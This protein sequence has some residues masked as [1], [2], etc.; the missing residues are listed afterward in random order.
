MRSGTG[1]VRANYEDEKTKKELDDYARE[2]GK[3]PKMSE[4]MI[5]IVVVSGNRVIGLDL[6]AN[7]DLLGQY[8][9]KLIKAYAMDALSGAKASVDKD[10][11][12][13][14]IESLNGCQ[15]TSTGTSGL[16]S[17]CKTENELGKGSVLVYKSAVIH[18]DFFMSHEIDDDDLRIDLRRNERLTD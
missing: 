16:G 2:F 8:W 17:L 5:G 15:F 3:F 10:D 12:E 6:F 13:N 18:L 4:A 7:N 14:L 9:D 11:I 1:T